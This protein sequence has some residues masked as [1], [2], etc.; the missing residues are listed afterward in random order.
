MKETSQSTGAGPGHVI[1][2]G[3][4]IG[5]LTAA[6]E[7]TTPRPGVT[8]PR[9]TVYQM[10]WRLG[11]KCATGRNPERGQRIEE[12]GIH[13]FLGS[14]FNALPLMK[15][16]YDEW[17]PPENCPIDSFET[18][19][20][21]EFEAF[22]WEWQDEALLRW[23]R[24]ARNIHPLEDAHKFATLQSWLPL[25]VR[26]L[27][28][29]AQGPGQAHI[30]PATR[31]AVNRKFDELIDAVDASAAEADG[32]APGS[33]HPGAE[34]VASLDAR[35]P[36]ADEQDDEERREA[37]LLEFATLLARGI[38][39]DQLFAKGLRSVDG[40][41]FLDWLK[42]HGASRALLKSPLVVATINTTYQIPEGDLTRRPTMSAASYLNWTLRGLVSLEAPYHLFAAGSG[43][44]IV[45]PMYEVLKERGVRFEFFHR[46]ADVGLS[47][48]GAR[49]THVTFDR[50]ARPV[51]DRFEPLKRVKNLKVWPDRPDLGQ[52]ENGQDYDGFDFESPWAHAP[53]TET[54][55]LTCGEDF[56]H[57]V[58]ALPPD[59][60]RIA[61]PGLVE[62]NARWRAAVDGATTVATQASQVWFNRKISDM[63]ERGGL[64]H[65]AGNFF[66][67]LHGHVDFSK[68]LAFE[69]WPADNAPQ[70]LMFFSGVFPE[71]DVPSCDADAATVERLVKHNAIEVLANGG[72]A[73]LPRAAAKTATPVGNPFGMDFDLLYSEMPTGAGRARFDDQ[74]WRLNWRP[75]ERYTQSPVGTRDKRI[76]PL[77]TGVERLT[78][79][80]DWV[81]TVLNV[82]SFE[83]AVMGGMLAASAIDPTLPRERIVGIAPTPAD[84]P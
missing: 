23:Y 38:V 17:V 31:A 75:S 35:V 66:T 15:K 7:L 37:L 34:R 10:G 54:V 55:R 43:D 11:G 57:L 72:R 33:G 46:L 28:V 48:D 22:F 47:G 44:T 59:A 65:L 56:D 29:E 76:S 49:L 14:Y 50:Q 45:A 51:N 69:D 3:G 19:F 67:G 1:I 9:V 24:P 60:I 74:Y 79:A 63:D 40:E 16:L 83:G 39:R 71:V 36:E 32:A 78:C 81:D 77:D 61:A 5:G 58:L 18:A 8:L 73:L 4:G 21:R 25:S 6:W 52:L 12:H 68:F 82:G 62:T 42:R 20:P 80:G 27:K 30:S 13:G 41:D 84:S 70:G 53:H 26:M 2:V 64:F